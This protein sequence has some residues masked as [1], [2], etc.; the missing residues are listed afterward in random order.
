M[1]NISDPVALAGKFDWRFGSL[2]VAGLVTTQFLVQNPQRVAI[3]L[4]TPNGV[5]FVGPDSSV[6]TTK[7]FRMDQNSQQWWVLFRDFG[8]LVGS[9]W[10]CQEIVG[11]GDIQWIEVLFFPER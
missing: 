4:T 1:A 7:G 11:G 9:D 8:S 10:Y 3:W 6:S 5:F 2:T